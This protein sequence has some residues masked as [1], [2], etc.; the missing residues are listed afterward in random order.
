MWYSVGMKILKTIL[1][2]AS[3]ASVLWVSYPRLAGWQPQSAEEQQAETEKQN[4]KKMI[5]GQE[6]CDIIRALAEM[7]C[8]IIESRATNN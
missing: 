8:K 3:L 2:I 1:A 6:V 7:E 5:Q 4:Q